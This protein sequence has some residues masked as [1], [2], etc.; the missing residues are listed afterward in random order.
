MRKTRNQFVQGRGPES[1]YVSLQGPRERIERTVRAVRRHIGRRPIG[2]RADLPPLRHAMERVRWSE[3]GA[4]LT[5]TGENAWD[6]AGRMVRLAQRDGIN[7][8]V[9]ATPPEITRTAV[10]PVTAPDPRTQAERDYLT[11]A[12]RILDEG[13]WVRNTRTGKQCLA[14]INADFTYDVSEGYVPVWTTKYTPWKQAIGEMLGYWRGLDNA[15]QFE[16][17]MGVNTWRANADRSPDWL[18]NPWRKGPGDIGRAYGVQARRWRNPEGVEIDQVKKVVDNLSAGIDDRREIITFLNPGEAERMALVACMH[19]H[20]FSLLGDELYLTSN[21]RSMDVPLG[22]GGWNQL[23]AAWLLMV[24]AQITGNR[25][26]QVFHKVAN[27]HLYEDQVQLMR[28][29]QLRREPVPVPRLRINPEIR[30]L[31]DMDTWVTPDDFELVGYKHAPAIRY[32][33]SP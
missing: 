19:T 2:S 15:E 5:L 4:V 16:T 8:S 11:L 7:T 26:M 14:V 27:L 9:Q 21:Q 31:E 28:D 32:P 13:R 29:E 24:M 25:P 22:G 1:V 18:N 12:Q 3:Q 20:T 33:F 6:I 23:Q 17:Q 10:P 30:T